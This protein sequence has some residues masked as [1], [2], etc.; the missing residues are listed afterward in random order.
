M[1][2]LRAVDQDIR[3]TEGRKEVA[4]GAAS[5]RFMSAATMPASLAQ[6]LADDRHGDARHGDLLVG[7]EF[8]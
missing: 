1:S 7:K 8:P 4:V 5:H 6:R 3:L 2:V